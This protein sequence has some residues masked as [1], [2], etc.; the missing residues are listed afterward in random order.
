MNQNLLAPKQAAEYLGISEGTLAVWR[1]NKT[2]PIPY[3]KVGNR[4]RYRQEDLE[5]WLDE[6]TKNKQI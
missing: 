6:R 5:K 2:Y 3:I 1:T 4:I